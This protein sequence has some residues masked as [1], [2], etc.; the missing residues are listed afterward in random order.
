MSFI[1]SLG[2]FWQYDFLLKALLGTIA[3]AFAT[4]V[5]SPIIVSKRYSFMGAAVSHSTLFGLAVSLTFFNTAS[6]QIHFFVTLIITLLFAMFLAKETMKKDLPSDS[7][8]GIFFSVMMALGIIIYSFKVDGQED[9]ISF[10]FGNI[11][12]LTNFDII[13]LATISLIIITCIT[14]YFSQWVYFIFDPLGARLRGIKITLLH[15]LLF[16]IMTTLIV[17]AIKLA[18][19]VLVTTLLILPGV[20]ALKHFNGSKQVFIY[21]TLFALVTSLMGLAMA[22]WLN[23]PS[24]ATLALTQFTVFSMSL[25]FK[26]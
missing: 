15:Y 26:K 3:L 21:S 22:N 10:L 2:D 19:T 12:L 1:T 13:L 18:G 6:E 8:I 9:L 14:V 7:L 24:G 4:G 17:T 5:I 25:V 23:T 16:I 20:F 11:L